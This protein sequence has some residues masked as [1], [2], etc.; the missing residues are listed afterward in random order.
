MRGL[1]VFVVVLLPL[2]AALSPPNIVNIP[3]QGTPVRVDADGGNLL[4]LAF[5]DKSVIGLY[6]VDVGS[7]VEIPLGSPVVKTVFS[8]GKAVAL[9]MPGNKLAVVE[10]AS[11]KATFVELEFTATSI[12]ADSKNIYVAY[13]RA[14][15]IDKLSAD[16]LGLVE[17]FSSALADGVD[18]LS[19]YESVVWTVSPSLD[20]VNFH[21]RGSGSV[22]VNGVITR[23]QAVKD[24]AW[25]ILSDDTVIMV[26][27]T[28]IVYRTNLPKAT[29]VTSVTALDQKLV[30]SSISRR[31]VGVVDQTGYREVN[32]SSYSPSSVATGLNRRIWFL[33]SL[34]KNVGYIFDS[35]PP[36]IFDWSMNRLQD[37]SAEVRAKVSDPDG[38]VASVTLVAIQYQGVYVLG[39]VS[40]PMDSVQE[41]YRGVYR[42]AAGV[43]RVE[44]YVNVTDST[45]NHASQKIGEVDYS[46]STT[47]PVLTT[48]TGTV[49]QQD[50][51]AVF[52][53]AAELL[54]LIP[55][56]LVVTF[57]AVNR[58][59][60][61]KTRKKK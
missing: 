15:R 58:K 40:T 29:F 48:Q 8:K 13:A 52:S 39:P 10:T 7:Y 55:L 35:Q 47:S 33:D 20:I 28:S 18:S 49:P 51:R 59:G 24:G 16:D 11:K 61:R 12:A 42:P 3:I 34:S 9:L 46:V 36:R 31:V 17:T 43:T 30:Y 57:F 21:G 22:K 44:L 2:A 32:M 41:F 53:I 37:G 6:Y 27:G 56:I 38:D 45:G 50:G 60:K 25:I 1:A 5:A 19:V 4:A 14:G 54:L 26:S 23:L